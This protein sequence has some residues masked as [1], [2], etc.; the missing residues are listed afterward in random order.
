MEVSLSNIKAWRHIKMEQKLQFMKLIFQTKYKRMNDQLF[1][2]RR[3]GWSLGIH[4]H[5][6]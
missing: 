6:W 4:G 2:N 1:D 3:N 5:S